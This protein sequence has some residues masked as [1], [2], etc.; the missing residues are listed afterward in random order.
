MSCLK[1]RLISIFV[2]LLI[3]CSWSMP[4][5]AE[6]YYN[7]TGYFD[8]LLLGIVHGTSS[9]P[10]VGDAVQGI[11]GGLVGDICSGSDDGLHHAAEFIDGTLRKKTV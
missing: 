3:L 11:A 1:K 8:Q 6:D 9:I 4:V 7:T 5:S 2:C 10:L